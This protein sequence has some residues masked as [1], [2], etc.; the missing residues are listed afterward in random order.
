MQQAYAL[1]TVLDTFADREDGPT[2]RD[3]DARPRLI[4]KGFK[5]VVIGASVK[6]LWVYLSANGG[7]PSIWRTFR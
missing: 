7:R 1:H 3:S 6:N 5:N 4:E 2:F